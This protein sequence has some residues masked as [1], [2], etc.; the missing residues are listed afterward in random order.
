MGKTQ[1]VEVIDGE[2][3]CVGQTLPIKIGC[4]DCR[5][6]HDVEFRI[7]MR[8]TRNDR[9]TRYKRKRDGITIKPIPKDK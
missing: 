7:E 6:V 2:W 1:D 4:C 5:L 3:F 9:A 8:V